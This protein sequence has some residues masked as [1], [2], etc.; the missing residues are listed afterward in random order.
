MSARDEHGRFSEDLA[1]YALGALEESEVGALR[2]HAEGCVVCRDELAAH[3]RAVVA[4]GLGVP[5]LTAPGALR[6]RVVD[7]VAADVPTSRAVPWA[8]ASQRGVLGRSRSWSVVAGA[9]ASLALGV[10]LGALVLAPAP[11][12]TSTVRASVASLRAWPGATTAPDAVLER[13]G[14]QA[15]L[16][17]THLPSAGAGKVYELWI[18]RGGRAHATDALFDATSGGNATVAVPGDLDGASAVLVTAEPHGGTQKPT[19]APLITAVL[20]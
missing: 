14:S 11:A 4:L 12:S 16:R 9:S 15:E 5:Q 2:S 10:A 13:S 18:E 7:G 17:V 8:A 19:M 6:R 20:S 1:A 3:G